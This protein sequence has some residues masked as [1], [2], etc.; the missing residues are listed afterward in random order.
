M[1]KVGKDNRNPST[2]Y[3]QSKG[4]GA[5]LILVHGWGINSAVW[6][7]TIERLCQSYRVHVM[8]L[9]G[10]GHSHHHHFNSM[11]HLAELV[12]EQAPE[13]AI[14]LGWSLGGLL[15]THIALHYPTRVAKLITVASSPR[16]A[17]EKK[18]RGI[19]PNVLTSFTDQLVADF[20]STINNF[21]S[22]QALG[23]PSARQDIK[24]L[25]RS[26]LTRPLPNPR[27]LHTGLQL[28]ANTDYREALSSVSI[29]TLRLYGRLDGLV[30]VGVAKA[31]DAL[32]PNSESYVFNA[33]SHAPFITELDDFCQ[34]V[35]QFSSSS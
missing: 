7:Q 12:L 28:L 27:A 33:S 9:P 29:P 8:D 24:H 19:Q 1:E 30:P 23:S 22:L 25:K 11:E 35:A 5:D 20:Q 6:D 10:F 21:M 31:V 18:W 2:L 34:Q 3:W 32:M 15:A 13:R 16:F 26:V 4:Q 14:W 17:A